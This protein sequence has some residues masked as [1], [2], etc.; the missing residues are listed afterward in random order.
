MATKRDYYEVLGVSKTATQDEIKSA[1]R[2][3]AKKYHPDISKEANAEE[4]F[5]EVQEAYSVLSDEKKRKQYDQFGHAAF[6]GG[7][8]AGN[9]YGGG[10]SGA[11]FCF[12]PG[13]LNDIFDDLFGGGF[14]FGG[15]RSSRRTKARRGEDVLI[16]QTLTFEEAVFGCEKDFDLDVVEECDA[17]HGKGGFGEHD[18]SRCHGSG[19]ITQE[20]HTILGSFVTKT[21]CPTCGGTGKTYEE[22]CSRCKGKGRVKNHKTITVSVPSG[23]DSG[24]RL[25]LPGKGQAGT[26]GGPNGDLYIEFQVKDHEFFERDGDDIYLEVPITMVEAVLGCKK[27]VPTIY[28]NITISIPS[29][30]DSGTKQRIR[31]KGIKNDSTRRTGDM[32][33]IYQV[34]TPKR[35]TRD[36]KK[37]FESLA[38][39]DFKD[40]DIDRFERFTKRNDK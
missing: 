30:C 6:E 36:Q 37:L 29:G 27:E 33:V 16:R 5:K 32:Y 31:G 17:C 10:F 9:P 15:S 20:Q 24:E 3:L 14:G 22:V 26:S 25:R 4:K 8:A 39:T 7:G 12:D 2:K 28:G 1:F 13:D 21:T 40:A 38:Q 35:L 23:I 18:C 11:G 34:Q 19:T